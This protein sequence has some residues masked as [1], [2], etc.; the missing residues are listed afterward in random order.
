MKRTVFVASLFVVVA[1]ASAA[2]AQRPLRA[3]VVSGENSFK[4][5][6]WKETSPALKAILDEGKTFQSVDVEF[7]PNY[8]ASEAFLS[9]DVAVFDFRNAKP[10]AMDGAVQANLLKFLEQGKG[11]VVIHWANGAFPYWAEYTNIVGRSQL[12]RHDKRGPLTV[13][14][15]DANHPITRGLKDYDTDDELYWDNKMGYRPTTTL[16]VAR[17]S[18]HENGDFAQALTVQYG[19]GRVFMTPLGHDVKALQ[20]PG[21]AELIRRGAAWAAGT[22]K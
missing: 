14:I 19:S 21:T 17:S 9:Y 5:H 8:V 18:I 4:G 3:V 12:S 7:D 22:L 10:L 20:V 15:I 2:V 1:V 16:A 6:V 11:L 13:R